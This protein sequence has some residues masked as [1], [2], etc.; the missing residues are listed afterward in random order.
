MKN[1]L[2]QK[3]ILVVL[4]IIA[5]LVIILTVSKTDDETDQPTVAATIF[6]LAD[7]TSNIA[8]DKIDVIQILPSGSSPHTFELTPA[9]VKELSQS[10]IVF[11]IGYGLDDWVEDMV[12]TWPNI[13][14]SIV[15][16]NIVLKESGHIHEHE[17]GEEEEEHEED[18]E[19]TDATDP[20]Y[21]LSLDNAR[22]IAANITS[23]LEAK[24]PEFKEYFEENLNT[25]F[26]SLNDLKDE[27]LNRFSSLTNKKMATFHDAWQYFADE[28]GLEIVTTFE[29]FPG[30]EPSPQYLVKFQEEITEHDIKVVFSE[31]QLSNETLQPFANDLDLSLAILDPLGGLDNR[32]SYIELIKYNTDIIISSLK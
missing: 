2:I 27:S 12:D 13:E 20:H 5:V 17:D 19:Q 32:Q 30:Q 26:D 22:T 7:I 23:S 14:I 29:P 8:G 3:I 24:F 28:M 1:N 21:W 9:K 6:P 16:E 15:S 11:G 31:P 25:Y 4:L 18:Q 10:E